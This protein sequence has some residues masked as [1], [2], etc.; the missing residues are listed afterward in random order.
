MN[1]K[2]IV[3]GRLK[4]KKSVVFRLILNNYLTFGKKFIIIEAQSTEGFYHLLCYVR[5]ERGIIFMDLSNQRVL[6]YLEEDNIQ[7][8][9]FRIRPLLRAQGP[10]TQEELAEFPDEGF[11]RIVPDKNEQHTFKDRMRLLGPVCMLNLLGVPKE[12]NK[13]RTNKN[14]A[15]H[16]GEVNQFIIYSDAVQALGENDLYEVTSKE[17]MQNAVTPFVYTREGGNIFG[18]VNKDTGAQ[19]EDADK[20]S[21]DSKGLYSVV[22]PDGAQ[23]LFFWKQEALEQVAEEAKQAVS[24]TPAVQEEKES[25]VASPSLSVEEAIQPNTP[26]QVNNFQTEKPVQ[27]KPKMDR[28]TAI[29]KIQALDGAATPTMNRL[30]DNT[31]SFAPPVMQNQKPLS[32]TPL[33]QAT[34]KKFAPTRV[35]NPFI[36]TVDSQRM[37]YDAP[38]AQVQNTKDMVNVSNPVEHFKNALTN[39]WRSNETHGQTVECILSMSGMR[40]LLAKAA[41]SGAS[42]LTVAAMHAQLNDLEAERLRTLMQLDEAK[43]NLKNAKEKVI[44][45]AQAN[46]KKALQAIE[47]EKAKIVESIRVL[48][49]EQ[50]AL[51]DQQAHLTEQ[52]DA[53]ISDDDTI[54][55]S[56]KVGENVSFKQLLDNVVASFDA[57]G[58]TLSKD[59]AC[60]MVAVY[61]LSN[62]AFG[63]SSNTPSDA[64]F[65]AC[66]L[67]NAF[68]GEL[69]FDEGNY[70]HV[71]QGGDAP[72]FV[73]S[74]NDVVKRKAPYTRIILQDHREDFCSFIIN[75]HPVC[76]VR[77]D[78][79][80]KGDVHFAPLSKS[81]IID[82]VQ[83]NKS[84]LNEETRAFINTLFDAFKKSNAHLPLIVVKNLIEFVECTQDKMQGGVMAALDLGVLT[85]VAPYMKA[86]KHSLVPVRPLLTS[87]PRTMEKA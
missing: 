29:Q 46:E 16:R 79:L 20:L 10:I 63:M 71:Q 44:L 72:C 8:A 35:N 40:E 70:V 51:M 61:A 7:R 32:G 87:L 28:E 11:M 9:F 80:P 13:I 34:P 83:E 21:P 1:A 5:S 52:I 30:N 31:S 19:R 27:E 6:V 81:A 74:E 54:L 14:F 50:N 53:L 66:A 86:T 58:F 45:E 39:V 69:A 26:V 67:N 77:A 59:E 33:Y 68:G 36:Q 41:R 73:V 57:N 60:A 24:E 43:N 22:F 12:A 62:R 2:F 56:P 49:E 76:S 25:A 15:P 23:K 78:H 48:K 55:L 3:L 37:R 4:W 64:Y 65:A 18:P 84:H 75:P 85:Y 38:G 42:D 47:N 82:M 17:C